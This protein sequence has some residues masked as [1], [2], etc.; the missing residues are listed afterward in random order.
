MLTFDYTYA[1]PHLNLGNN[2]THEHLFYAI[3]ERQTFGQFY[4]ELTNLPNPNNDALITIKAK[5]NFGYSLEET[6]CLF[7]LCECLQH[8]YDNIYLT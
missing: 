3:A 5:L 6:F 1:F 4:E 2:F 8:F 7:E